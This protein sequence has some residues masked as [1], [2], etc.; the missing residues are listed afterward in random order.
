MERGGGATTVV[1]VVVLVV[2]L[3]VAGVGST[4]ARIGTRTLP[5]PPLPADAVDVALVDDDDVAARIDICWGPVG[6]MTRDDDD[7]MRLIV[8]EDVV[9]LIAEVL[10]MTGAIAEG[11]TNEELEEEE[12]TLRAEGTVGRGGGGG[13]CAMNVD[14]APGLLRTAPVATAVVVETCGGGRGLKGI[15][16]RG[17]GFSTGTGILVEIILT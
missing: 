4:D 17:S 1:V 15:G 9:A 11:L 6:T 8:V 13:A 3:A 12:G 7:A 14:P 16:S 2:A 5:L 10:I